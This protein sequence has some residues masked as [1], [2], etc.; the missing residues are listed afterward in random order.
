MDEVA[1][2]SDRSPGPAGTNWVD[3]VAY[4]RA[5]RHLRQCSAKDGFWASTLDRANYHRVWGRDG[6]IIGLA[7]LCTGDAELIAT[8]ERTLQT[9]A[10]HQGPHGEIPSNVDGRTGRVS[11]G[12]TT[13]RVDA[14][15]WFVIG[16]AEFWDVTKDRRL[17]KS[18]LPGIRRVMNL[19]ASWEFNNRGLIYV[20]QTG[21]WADEYVHSGYVLYDQL[22]YLQAQAGFVALERALTGRT[23]PGALKRI[24]RLR[25]LI[26]MNYW[27][28]DGEEDME[29]AYHEVLYSKGREAAPHCER[30][31]MPFFM[32]S[33]YGYRFDAFANV[34][35]SLL[36]VA[37]ES[38][39]RAVDDY[40]QE[41]AP[42]QLSLLPAFHPTIKPINDDWKRL[43]MMFSY[44]F[45]NR[46]HEYQNGGLWPMI[47]GFYVAD[48]AARGKTRTARRYLKAIHRANAMEMGGVGPSFPEYVHGKKLVP[49][50]T[51]LMG[52][53]AAVAV[54]GE[55]ALHGQ[56]VFR[57]RCP[58]RQPA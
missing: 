20:P 43:N 58:G 42:K 9:L 46:P 31:W 24:E 7:A 26:R 35:V 34:L 54:M 25:G 1:R 50:G 18:I 56:P 6:I 16:C 29:D 57:I 52:W 3:A 17:L 2:S 39:R 41:I 33:G 44:T 40:I 8:F 12:G 28:H 5:L 19:L 11:Y 30:Y 55:H 37:D 49:G 27:F 53:S 45:R 36:D 4:T 38:Q 48:L 51:P 15:L 10:G 21:D 47:T 13:G 22:L 14:D 32:P 23:P